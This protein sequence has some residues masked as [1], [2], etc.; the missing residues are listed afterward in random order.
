MKDGTRQWVRPN[1]RPE[2]CQNHYD[3]PWDPRQDYHV[4]AVENSR[5]W[6]VWYIDGKEVAKKPNLYWHL[7]MHVTLSLGL[8]YPFVAYKDGDR[9]PVPEKTTA[10]GFP[11]SMS[12]DYVRVWQKPDD[13]AKKVTTDWTKGEFIEN[14][15]AKWANNGW[16]WDQGKVESNFDEIDTI[17]VTQRRKLLMPPSSVGWITRCQWLGIS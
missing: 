15:K 14:E 7:P 9:V 5:D 13:A 10:E 1:N 12:V 11:T 16:P 8:R 3:S 6:I 4:Y 17:D 2:L